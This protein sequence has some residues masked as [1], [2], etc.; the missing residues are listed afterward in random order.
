MLA[1]EVLFSSL[2]FMCGFR[3][4]E[5]CIQPADPRIP[6][7]VVLRRDVSRVIQIAATVGHATQFY[8]H[9]GE[10]TTITIVELVFAWEEK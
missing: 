7:T 4:Q 10:T 2:R 9:A 1:R 8:P 5:I 6:S 3:S